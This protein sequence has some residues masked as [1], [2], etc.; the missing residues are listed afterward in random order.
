[1]YSILK[2]TATS[3]LIERVGSPLSILGN[4]VYNMLLNKFDFTVQGIKNNLLT[5]TTAQKVGMNL[6]SFLDGVASHALHATNPPGYVI[7]ALDMK[8]RER[9]GV[10]KTPEGYAFP[11]SEF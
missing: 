9:Y 5:F 1:M 6:L 8:L 11:H 3:D 10:V 7:R 2:H 4:E